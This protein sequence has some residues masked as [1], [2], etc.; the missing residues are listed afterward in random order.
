MLDNHLLIISPSSYNNLI[1][2]YIH[3][4]TVLHSSFHHL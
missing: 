3:L 2:S 1:S 4:F